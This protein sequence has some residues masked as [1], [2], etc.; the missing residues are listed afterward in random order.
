MDFNHNLTREDFY[1]TQIEIEYSQKGESCKYYLRRT[2]KVLTAL[3]GSAGEIAKATKIK[4]KILE[5][6]IN[7][8][9]NF[10]QEE[11][12]E[13]NKDIKI[14]NYYFPVFGLLDMVV[15]SSFWIENE[16]CTYHELATIIGKP[17]H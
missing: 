11:Q 2:P 6:I 12:S 15:E 14:Q 5:T 13:E 7:D 16:L 9:Q 8:I 3:T 10:L 17:Y 1:P 4:Q